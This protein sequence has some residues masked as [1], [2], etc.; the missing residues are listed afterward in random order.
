MSFKVFIGSTMASALLGVGVLAGSVVGGGSASAQ[1]NSPSAQAATPQPTTTVPNSGSTTPASPG[2]TPSGMGGRGGHGFGDGGFGHGGMFGG[3]ATAD[4]ATQAITNVTA[5]ITTVQGDLT[6]ATG[7]MDTADVQRWISGAQTLL[8]SA[9]SANSGS[10]YGQA[11]AYADAAREL[12]RTADA[13]MAQKLGADKLPSY[14]Q[15][16]LLNGP[17]NGK[18]MQSTSATITQAQAS[19]QLAQTYNR[20]VSEAAVVKSASNASEATPYLTDAQNAYKVAYS[21]YQAGNYTDA[22]S[23]ARLAG[24]LAQVAEAIANASSAPANSTTPVN[25]PAPDFQ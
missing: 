22:A 11:V 15:Q 9:Q 20:L 7:K 13:Q 24:Q 4:G 8:K 2:T 6:Y 14:N 17:L 10:Q 21:S 18:D 16:T 1:V 23:S 3:N 25:V 19:R 5:L 12:L